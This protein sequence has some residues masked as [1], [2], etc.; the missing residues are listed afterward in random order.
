MKNLIAEFRGSVYQ[1][2]YGFEVEVLKTEQGIYEV[3]TTGVDPKDELQ[4]EFNSFEAFLNELIIKNPLWFTYYFVRVDKKYQALVEEKLRKTILNALNWLDHSVSYTVDNWRFEESYLTF[5]VKDQMQKVMEEKYNY[6]FP[7]S[8]NI[9]PVEELNTPEEKWELDQ[10]WNG[11]CPES[12]LKGKRVRMRLN[13]NDLFESEET[14]LQIA[15]IRGLQ[16]II[17]KKRGEGNFRTEKTYGD[18]I[19]NGELLSPQTAIMPP[20]NN[21]N[22]VFDNSEEIENYINKINKT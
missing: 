10:M 9:Q 5:S 20:F 3:K 1:N 2:S 11:Y 13:N 15:V 12:H 22:V 19:E 8:K 6:F 16:A 17:L 21:N 7:E 18:I 14:G 4:N